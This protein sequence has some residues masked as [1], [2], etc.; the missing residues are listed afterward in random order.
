MNTSP[1]NR[2]EARTKKRM[3]KPLKVT[4]IVIG[5]LIAIPVL[6]LATTSIGNAV[7]T[8]AEVAAVQPYGEKVPVDGKEMNVV[9]SGTGDTTI[10]LLP[11]L[12]TAAPGLD[13]QPLITQLDSTYRV[14]AVEPFG[15]GLSDQ[16]DKPR[17]AENI[18]AEVHEALQH[19]G[20]HR[21]VLMGH[22]ISGIYALTYSAAYADE[23]IAFVGIDSSVPGQ[24][25]ADEPMPTE[26]IGT[27]GALGITRL[28]G[29]SLPDQ[30]DGLPYSATEKSDMNALAAKNG[31]APTLLDEMDHAP[32][33]FAAASGKTFPKD[34]PL[35]LFV[36]TKDDDV[37]GWVELHQQQA[38]SVDNGKVVL[39]EGE[40]Y[41][42]HRFSAE[43]A[44]DTEAFLSAL[45]SAQ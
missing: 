40:H 10:V 7:A 31:A 19:L 25:G 45:P 27:L 28:L 24:P 32:A 6:A 14:V 30:Y 29:A 21:Y 35:L 3:N 4:L 8:S 23:L 13:F 37:A 34:L 1:E 38:A 43:I 2:I 41:L 5:A 16:T 12:G 20:I 26:A 17:T 18:T 15:T 9:V 33:N 44:Q 11:G 39:I 42:H 22:S 36:N